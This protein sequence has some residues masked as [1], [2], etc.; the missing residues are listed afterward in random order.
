MEQLP[1]KAGRYK[2]LEVLG[3]GGTGIV[4]LACQTD[5]G[6]HVAVKRLVNLGGSTQMLNRFL[7]EAE[8]S[9]GLR[10]QN[11]VEIYEYFEHDGEVHSAM[12]LM[13][14]GTLLDHMRP[15]GLQT[16]QVGGVLTG[17]LAALSCAADRRIVHRD[18]KPENVLVGDEGQVKLTDFGIARAIDVTMAESR[19]TAVGQVVGS[20][21]YMAPEQAAGEEVGHS[22]DCYSA[23]VI[24]YELLLGGK[25][26]FPPAESWEKSRAQRVNT[27]II[28]PLEVC[29]K[30]DP[31][32][33][34]WLERML[35]RT[36]ADRHRSAA[37]A[38][39]E[40]DKH[41][42]QMLGQHWRSESAIA[43]GPLAPLPACK[44]GIWRLLALAT[45]LAVLAA[46]IAERALG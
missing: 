1:R 37:H 4:Y 33:A 43:V 36:P 40:L 38:S 28:P 24:A 21:E 14:H 23:G 29:P 18:V 27:P 3:R 11:I 10:H 9:E 7:R 41:L 13:R 44:N 16:A 22:A 25:R 45:T 2:L 46:V 8:L 5:R 26:P 15:P 31:G 35:Q 20:L 30:L 6:R 42:V 34:A 17:I 12:E 39:E 19:L 32:L